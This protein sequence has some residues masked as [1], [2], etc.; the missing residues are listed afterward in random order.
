MRTRLMLWPGLALG[1][2]LVTFWFTGTLDH[3]ADYAAAGQ[4]QAQNALAT[5]LRH[6]RAGDSGAFLALIGI[7]FTYGV[8]H[9][10]GPGHGKVLIGGYGVA[11]RVRLWP[12]VGIALLSSLAQATSAV[13]LVYAGVKLLDLTRERMVDL[14]ER[15]FAPASYAAIGLIGLWLALRGV[16]RLSR[17]L[18]DGHQKAVLSGPAHAD[19]VGH[20]GPHR[21]D[22]SLLAACAPSTG[23][24]VHDAHCGH[25]HGP[26]AEEAASVASVRDALVLIG[27]IAIRPCTGAMFL[28]ILCWRM[29][30]D[31]VGIAGAYA[32][33]LG[34]AIVTIA[35]A[36]LAVWTREG[37]FN[38]LSIGRLARA[39]PLVEIA[40]G[41]TV[42][43]ISVEMLRHAI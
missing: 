1:L 12:L 11:R 3:V 32:M 26:T 10:V 36:G 2:M 7:A 22:H 15:V 24:H 33:G 25:R 35:V 8:F 31:A 17:G 6:L 38:A 30:I 20:D 4:K 39:L 21:H 28:L 27:G 41:L 16:R 18:R 40:A 14:T 23:A 13:V 29:K 34:T 5:S 19:T 42:A 9:A 43:A 37:A